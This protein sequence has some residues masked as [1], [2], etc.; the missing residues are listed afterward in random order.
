MVIK[1]YGDCKAVLAT[2]DH[3]EQLAPFLRHNDKLEVGAYGFEDPLEALT[4]ALDHDEVTITA[5]DKDDVPFAMFGVGRGYP[6][7]YIW[8]L[9]SDSVKDNWYPFAKASRQ[10]L[11]ILIKDYPI[12]YNLVLKDYTDSVKWLKWLGAIFTRDV[13]LAGHA[14]YEFVIVNKNYKKS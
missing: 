10:L 1:E 4:S 11:P 8:L 12:V 9:G 6:S 2:K 3:A 13:H 7:D 5:L 14:F